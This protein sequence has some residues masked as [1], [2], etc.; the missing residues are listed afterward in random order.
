MAYDPAARRLL[1]FGGSSVRGQHGRVLSDSWAW[2]GTD[3]TPLRGV[4]LP[5]WMPAAPIA[6]DPAARR[7][8]ELAPRPGYPGSDPW[9]QT[10]HNS[11][12]SGRVGRWLWTGRSWSFRA[13]HP[14]PG[15]EGGVLAPDPL[16]GGMLYFSYT[17]YVGSYGASP[18]DPAGT[19]FSQTWL[20]QDGHFTKQAPTRAPHIGGS[21]LMV[22]DAR[23]GRV[24]LA[25]SS[26][27]LWEWTGTTWQQLAS[28]R[29]PKAAAAAVYD[30]ALGDLIVLATI[31]GTGSPASQTWLWNGTRWTAAP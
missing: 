2:N 18:A 4:R 28:G 21:L 23:I 15:T 19:R 11:T 12:G 24:V 1:L 7:V 27:R 31:A 5:T 29:G 30:P 20:W 8:T 3:W 16:S 25:G 9:A 26:G 17:P 22:S 13:Q 14:A 10:F 6:W